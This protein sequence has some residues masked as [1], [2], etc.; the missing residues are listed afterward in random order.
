VDGASLAT[1]AREEGG[2]EEYSSSESSAER[3]RSRR[4]R[5]KASSAL[6]SMILSMRSVGSPRRFLRV[7]RAGS[8]DGCRRRRFKVGKDT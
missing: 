2:S 3:S 4:S 8:V 5:S 6:L 1:A 7:D